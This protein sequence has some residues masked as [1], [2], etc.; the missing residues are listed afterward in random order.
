MK[1]LKNISIAIGVVIALFIVIGL[2]LPSKWEV[3]KSLAMTASPERIYHEVANLHNWTKWSPWTYEKDKTLQY[4]YTGPEIG[5]GA[6]QNWTSEKMGK[7][8]LKIVK[9]D[10]ESGITYEL[11]ID[12]NNF[13]STLNGTMVFEAAGDQTNVIWTDTGDSGNNLLRRWMSLGMGSMLGAEL[14]KGLANLKV[15]V[16]KEASNNGNEAKN[17]AAVKTDE[18]VEE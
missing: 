2:F 9:A 15:L 1:V 8:W 17:D 4:T 16:E 13:Q 5:V 7:G 11:F 12:M 18:A 3:S 10:P 6:Q 14:E